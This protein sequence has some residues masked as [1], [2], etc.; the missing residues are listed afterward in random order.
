M[1][2]AA[3]KMLTLLKRSQKFTKAPV[4][5]SLCRNKDQRMKQV[6]GSERTIKLNRMRKRKLI[7]RSTSQRRG[8]LSGKRSGSNV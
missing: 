3:R 7:Y 1:R 6:K 2:K 4:S 8:E 5:R